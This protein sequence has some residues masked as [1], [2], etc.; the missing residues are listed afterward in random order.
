[1]QRGIRQGCPISALLFILCMEVMTINLRQDKTINGFVLGNSARKLSA[2]ADETTLLLKDMLSIS[3]A[4]KHVDDFG[5]IA[6]PKLNRDKCE[7]IWLGR[8]STLLTYDNTYHL[9]MSL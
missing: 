6:G 5:Q 8:L 4:L 1:M 2:Y 9:K 3:K 7:G